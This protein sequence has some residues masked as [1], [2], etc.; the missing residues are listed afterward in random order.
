MKVRY[1]FFLIVPNYYRNKVTPPSR[2][3]VNPTSHVDQG[4]YGPTSKSSNGRTSRNTGV[5]T[6]ASPSEIPPFPGNRSGNSR[7]GAGPSTAAYGGAVAPQA[8]GPAINP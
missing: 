8:T 4:P 7:A 5:N 1:G 2:A 6:T 3:G